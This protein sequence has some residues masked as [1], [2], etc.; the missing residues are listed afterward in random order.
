MPEAPLALPLRLMPPVMLNAPL[1]PLHAEALH[2]QG[3]GVVGEGPD[4]AGDYGLG[5]AGIAAMIAEAADA[6]QQ[7]AAEFLRQRD[8]AG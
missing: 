3:I 7:V 2:V 8:A 4:V 6:D 5:E 1:P